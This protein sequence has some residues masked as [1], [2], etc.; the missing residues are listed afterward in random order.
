M[1]ELRITDRTAWTKA[2]TW[3]L[4]A[5]AATGTGMTVGG[6]PTEVL[7]R[8]ATSLPGSA[9]S[10]T[11]KLLD[12]RAAGSVHRAGPRTLP[13]G[14]EARDPVL[15]A[16]PALLYAVRPVQRLGYIGNCPVKLLRVPGEL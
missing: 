9:R 10:H 8:W 4:T 2:G 15:A 11:G 12:R 6:A 14:E 3:T 7:A 5:P 16:A 1:S 13:I